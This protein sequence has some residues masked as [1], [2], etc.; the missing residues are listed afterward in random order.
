MPL[1]SDPC[2]IGQRP[3]TKWTY[4][5]GEATVTFGDAIKSPDETFPPRE[6]EGGNRATAHPVLVYDVIVL[7]TIPRLSS[8]S[9]N[10]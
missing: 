5:L 8:K 3:G 2:P 4:A 6:K 10:E 9:D 1:E 7:N